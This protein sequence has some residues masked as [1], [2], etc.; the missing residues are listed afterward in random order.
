MPPSDG[1]HLGAWPTSVSPPDP[2]HP[3][4]VRFGPAPAKHAAEHAT[5]GLV[6]TAQHAPQAGP[7]AADHCHPGCVPASAGAHRTKC[8]LRT[9]PWP[10]HLAV[11]C[12]RD[13][14][15][16]VALRHHA[17]LEHVVG[18]PRGPAQQ[19]AAGLPVP[20]PAPRRAGTLLRPGGQQCWNKALGCSMQAQGLCFSSLL[21][22]T[23]HWARQP[24][25]GCPDHQTPKPG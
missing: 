21:W 16:V 15:L 4:S 7:R 24:L 3:Q 25:A 19:R 22:E 13:D 9:P 1:A 6:G 2:R 10:P 5:H 23:W 18:V 17:R 8:S 14:C 12:A 11:C 20:E